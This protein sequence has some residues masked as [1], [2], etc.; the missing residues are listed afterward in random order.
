MGSVA[1]T[2]KRKD[3]T[4]CD[5]ASEPSTKTASEERQSR[6][7]ED[8]ESPNDGALSAQSHAYGNLMSALRNRERDNHVNADDGQQSSGLASAG[9]VPLPRPRIQVVHGTVPQKCARNTLPAR[10]GILCRPAL[11]TRTCQITGGNAHAWKS[12]Y[13]SRKMSKN[14]S[15]IFYMII[16]YSLRALSCQTLFLSV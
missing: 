2:S 5:T 9:G 11:G 4:K 15:I 1:L 6:G 3:L 14:K 10:S 12:K 8:D 7:R 16:Q 13:P